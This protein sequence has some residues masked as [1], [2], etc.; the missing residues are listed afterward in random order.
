M[1]LLD[2]FNEFSLLHKKNEKT[3]GLWDVIVIQKFKIRKLTSLVFGR[4]CVE[5]MKLTYDG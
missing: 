3:G 5:G 2:A 1:H 4:N